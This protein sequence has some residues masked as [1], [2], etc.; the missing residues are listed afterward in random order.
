MIEALFDANVH[1]LKVVETL[2]EKDTVKHVDANLEVADT[3]SLLNEYI[4]EVE[5]SVNK[6]QLKQIMKTL[7]TESCEVV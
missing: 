3:L 2:V 4:D 7:Y 5:I 6:N 1:D